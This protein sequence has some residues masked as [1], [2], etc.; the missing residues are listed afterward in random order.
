MKKIRIES[1]EKEHEAVREIN[2]SFILFGLEFVGNTDEDK[3]KAIIISNTLRKLPEYV[4]SKTLDEVLFVNMDS[5]AGKLI[6]VEQIKKTGKKAIILLNPTQSI[7]ESVLM[8]IIT[9]EIAHFML[10]HNSH[11]EGRKPEEVI[12]KEAC[13]LVEE[14]GFICICR[15][16]I[17]DYQKSKNMS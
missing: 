16:G 3:Q 6:W 7:E 9:H 2:E 11:H 14:W 4:K 10:D 12:E 17:D 5:I 13:D 15:V 8:S 1:G